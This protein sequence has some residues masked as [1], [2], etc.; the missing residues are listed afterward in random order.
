MEKI[1]EN[2]DIRPVGLVHRTIAFGL[3]F[4]TTGLIA[5][6][7]AVVFTGSTQSFGVAVARAALA[8]LR[9]FVGS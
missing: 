3:A 4:A 6:S 9:A 8:P 5:T 2:Q 1:N 7:V